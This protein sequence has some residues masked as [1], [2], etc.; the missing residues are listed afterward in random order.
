LINGSSYDGG[1]VYGGT[2]NNCTLTGNSSGSGGGANSSTLN[3]CT[4]TGN[5]A[6][7]GGGAYSSTLNNCA[8]TGNSAEG[9]GGGAYGTTL[10]NC[11]LAGNS[12]QSGGG[13]AYSSTLNNCMLSGNSAGRGGGAFSST[14]NNCTLMGNSAS[15]DGGGA[16]S[17]TLNNCII[18]FNS[19]ANYYASTLNYS[20]TA[21]QPAG[22]IGNIT[23]APLFLDLASGNL[24]LQ[25]NSPCINT[26][27]NN[28]VVGSTDLDGRPRLVGGTVDIGAYEFQLGLSGQFLGWLQRYNL[29]LDGSADFTDPDGDGVDNYHEWLAGSDPTNP[30]SFAPLLT[31]IPQC[32]NVILTWPTNAVG[33]T[34]QSTT[35]LVSAAGWSTNSPAPVVIAGQNTVTNPITGAQMFFRLSQ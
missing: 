22:G 7:F 26:G 13:G 30:F 23:N 32:A 19:G 10:N 24:R 28:Y 33:F 31:L 11:T 8:L 2:L 3:N 16:A 1:G 5:S 29:P 12:A 25:S 17:S 18:Y 27:D 34:L 6:F 20:C 21:P 15:V 9:L 4:L 14:L 35:N